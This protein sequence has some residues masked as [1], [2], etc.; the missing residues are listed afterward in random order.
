MHF[1]GCARKIR[2]STVASN[3][4]TAAPLFADQIPPLS[5]V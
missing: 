3:S 5:E 2:S 4:L 1:A